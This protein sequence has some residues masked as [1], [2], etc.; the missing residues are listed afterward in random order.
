MAP[1]R[2][3]LRRLALRGH[4]Q[5][6]SIRIDSNAP[7][8]HHC[9]GRL[10]DDEDEDEDV[11]KGDMASI[12]HGPLT[13]RELLVREEDVVEAILTILYGSES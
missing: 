12:Q 4:A 10:I 7:T 13:N 5:G 2:G 8:I 3:I 11:C 6:L 1:P 9:I